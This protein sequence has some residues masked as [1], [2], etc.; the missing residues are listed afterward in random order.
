MRLNG[1]S[2][3]VA[4]SLVLGM[5]LAA[6]LALGANAATL[7]A[8]SG[9]TVKPTLKAPAVKK[10]PAAAKIPASVTTAITEIR[11][12]FEQGKLRDKSSYFVDNPNAELTTEVVF[13]LLLKPQGKSD[14]MDAYIKWQILS[15]L[16]KPL[17]EENIP[18]V[19]LAYRKAPGVVTRP[20]MTDEQKRS[21]DKDLRKVDRMGAK[22]V[23]DKLTLNI[24]DNQTL[25][26]PAMAYRKALWALL[27]DDAHGFEAALD[28]CLYCAENGML[29]GNMEDVLLDRIR[30]WV[31]DNKQDMEIV[32]NKLMSLKTAKLP[33][34]Y[35]ET[36]FDEKS[37][38]YRW[39]ERRVDI[40]RQTRLDDTINALAPKLGKP[41]I[42]LPNAAPAK[43]ATPAPTKK[44]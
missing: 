28:D 29:Y 44:N 38:L 37:S 42:V 43:K 21:L 7:P 13:T 4:G 19:V 16:P 25:N 10:K 5:P 26:A 6:P 33:T 1:I 3:W 34:Y 39:T 9:S 32:Y 24:R 36:V 12:E 17:P 22:N 14:P 31:T 15:G 18:D 41:L 8:R 11:R 2:R 27:P 35:D 30:K 23:L 40:T 20:G